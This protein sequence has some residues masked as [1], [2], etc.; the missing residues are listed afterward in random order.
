MKGFPMRLALKQNATREI[1]MPIV[2][3]P[4]DGLVMIY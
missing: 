2:K 1:A 4:N 3:H